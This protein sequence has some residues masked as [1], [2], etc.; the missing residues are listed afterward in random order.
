M[1][2]QV[3]LYFRNVRA[4]G[5]PVTAWIAKAAACDIMLSSD[6]SRSTLAEYGGHIKLGRHW[7]YSLLERMNFVKIKTTTAKSKC[8][9]DDFK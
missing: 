2:S 5:G 8:M 3:L 9:I 1:E 7:A 6:T 4:D